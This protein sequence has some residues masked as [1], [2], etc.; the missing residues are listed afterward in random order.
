MNQRKAYQ[1][2]DLFLKKWTSTSFG[3]KQFLTAAP[4]LLTAC[5][6]GGSNDR[7]RE[8]DNTGQTTSMTVEDEKQLTQ[9]V[10]PEMKKDY[11]AIN[12]SE[13]QSYI[14]DLGQRIVKANDLNNK[15]Y[16]YNFT[17]VGVGYVNAFALPAG[18]VFVTAPLI[19]MAESEA[20]LAG[21]VGHEVGHIQARHTAER[22][23]AAKQANSS[24]WK[25]LLGG[26][27]IGG[28]IGLAAGAKV[29]PPKDK[30]CIA[31]AAAI[32]AAAGAAGGFL[33]QKYQF[34][35]NSRE[36]E[37]EAD[38]IGFKTAVGAGFSKA[39]VGKFYEKL[40]SMEQ[41]AK[42]DM[43]PIMASLSDAMST[44]PPSKE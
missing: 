21:V 16:S 17:V 13:L 18:T 32:G 2:F 44:H 27:G 10:L 12:D 1:E 40:L 39:H 7:M 33:V 19:A 6:A 3:R 14:S 43:D 8:G 38:R 31:K 23:E 9:E 36:D 4:L 5:S 24:L 25:Y 41:N 26:A 37:M 15:P 42:K 11:P 29:C 34:M 35:A 28:L 22:M 30:A 20:E